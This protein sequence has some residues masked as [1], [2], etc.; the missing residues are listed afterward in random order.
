MKE[1]YATSLENT[2]VDKSKGKDTT[3]EHKIYPKKK[4]HEGKNPT[5]K[6]IIFYHIIQP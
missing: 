3:Y 1:K 5:S 4:Y 6:S 2:T